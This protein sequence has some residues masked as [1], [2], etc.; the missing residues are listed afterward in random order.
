MGE[1]GSNSVRT[2]A[3]G[4]GVT[5]NSVRTLADDVGSI[6]NSVRTHADDVGSISNSVSDVADAEKSPLTVLEPVSV[7]FSFIKKTYL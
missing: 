2:L 7:S 4:A 1:T 5:S 3:D 6:S